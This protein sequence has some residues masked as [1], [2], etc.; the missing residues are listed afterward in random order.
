MRYPIILPRKHW[1]TKLI[2]K[3]HPYAPHFGG[4]FEIMIKAA[5]RA[6]TVILSKADVNDELLTTF[7]GAEAMINSRPLT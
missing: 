5:K 7:C 4:V 6:V 3:H 1:V 2:V